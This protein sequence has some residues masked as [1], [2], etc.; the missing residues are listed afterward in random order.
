MPVRD[1]PA[2]RSVRGA[3]RV[4]VD[5]LVVVSGVGEA[6]DLVLGDLDPSLKPSSL[7]RQPG[8]LVDVHRNSP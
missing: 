1:Q 7:A 2:E 6:V 5:P 8:Q 3:D 4:E